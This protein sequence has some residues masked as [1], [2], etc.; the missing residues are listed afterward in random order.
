MR[1]EFVT[2]FTFYFVRAISELHQCA[3]SLLWCEKGIVYQQVIGI[4]VSYHICLSSFMHPSVQV[5]E[6]HKH[7]CPIVMYRPK[8]FSCLFS[9]KK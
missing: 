4:L 8:L 1:I 9:S 6:L 7:A 3:Y 5:K 2:R